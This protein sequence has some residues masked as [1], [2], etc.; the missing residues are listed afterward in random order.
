MNAVKQEEKKDRLQEGVK[1]CA[2]ALKKL[3]ESL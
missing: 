3:T 2:E 1:H